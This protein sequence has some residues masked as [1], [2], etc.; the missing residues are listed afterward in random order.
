[1][2]LR[3]D[4]DAD[5]AATA[6]RREEIRAARRDWAR[7]GDHLVRRSA[8]ATTLT[9]RD[10]WCQHRD[11]VELVEYADPDTAAMV[12]TEIVVTGGPR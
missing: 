6:V 7:E 5:P 8:A 10:Q 4:G 1:V 11:G 3:P 9:E 2:A 12:R